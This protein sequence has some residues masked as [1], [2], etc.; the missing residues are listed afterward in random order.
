MT[1]WQILQ[2]IYNELE[3]NK[4]VSDLNANLKTDDILQVR[5]NLNINSNDDI[6]NN[7]IINK[8]SANSPK[9]NMMRN[10]KKMTQKLLSKRLQEIEPEL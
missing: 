4:Q 1:E 5:T 7:N 3:E 8:I 10:V 2:E 9:F 6:V